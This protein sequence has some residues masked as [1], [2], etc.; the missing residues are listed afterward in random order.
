[1]KCALA[2]FTPF[3]LS[4]FTACVIPPKVDPQ[5]K[6]R[7]SDDVSPFISSWSISFAIF[8]IFHALISVIYW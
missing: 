6:M 1:M 4:L 8:S 2:T 7:V 5:P 3:E